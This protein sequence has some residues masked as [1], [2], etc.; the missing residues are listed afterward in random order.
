MLRFVSFRKKINLT[1]KAIINNAIRTTNTTEGEQSALIKIYEN[2]RFNN[3][4]ILTIIWYNLILPVAK[5]VTQKGPDKHY[6]KAPI[7]IN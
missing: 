6:I 5:I 1:I 7:I 4:T 2:G 3:K